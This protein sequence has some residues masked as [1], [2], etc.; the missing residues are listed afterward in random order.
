MKHLNECPQVEDD[1]AECSCEVNGVYLRCL[2]CEKTLSYAEFHKLRPNQCPRCGTDGTPATPLLDATVN[3]NWQE[4][5][6][7]CIWAERFASA[8]AAQGQDD[9][10]N[11]IKLVYAIA[12]RLQKQY[13]T[14]PVLTL[15]GEL[16]ELKEAAKEMGATLDTA[17]LGVIRPDPKRIT[18]VH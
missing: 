12:D 16:A 6:V 17:N 7:L 10:Q 8:A 2:I 13:P 5:R 11:M 14:F 4:L 15:A 18:R 9:D 1:D 3:L